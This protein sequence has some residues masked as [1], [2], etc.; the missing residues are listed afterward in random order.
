MTTTLRCREGGATNPRRQFVVF[1]RCIGYAGNTCKVMSRHSAVTGESR[2]ESRCKS[3][4]QRG[5]VEGGGKSVNQAKSKLSSL[6]IRL[7]SSAGDKL[8]GKL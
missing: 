7:D 5:D 3:E 2:A 8:I 6:G 4:P 1:P